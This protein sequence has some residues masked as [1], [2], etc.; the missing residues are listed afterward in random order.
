MSEFPRGHFRHKSVRDPL[1]GFVDLSKTETDLIDTGVFRRLHSIKQLSH[2][3]VVYPSAIHTRFEH[4]LGTLHVADRMCSELELEADRREIVR[5]TAL[6][7][8]IGHGPF[9]HLFEKVLE[10]INPEIPEPH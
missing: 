9:S 6:L 1:Y 5:M 3:Y 4:S 7:H 8:D 10:R 2:A